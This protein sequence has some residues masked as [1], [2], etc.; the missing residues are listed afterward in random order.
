MHELNRLRL[1]VWATHSRFGVYL[2]GII[3]GFL[4][5]E[6]KGRKIKIHSVS[7]MEIVQIPQALLIFRFIS[8][9]RP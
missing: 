6:L 2:I 1:I 8:N 9:G 3:L 4:F 7:K 5:F